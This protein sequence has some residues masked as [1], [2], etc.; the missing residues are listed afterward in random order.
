M[1]SL[2]L[3]F[4]LAASAFAG[5]LAEVELTADPP[6]P[7]VQIHSVRFTPSETRTYD[8]LVFTCSYRQSFSQPDASGSVTN[9]TH[10]PGFPFVYRE[11]NAHLVA[12]LDKYIAFRVPVNVQEL[13]D[14]FGKTAFVTNAPVT[15]QSVKVQALT[16]G[17]EDWK[18]SIAPG[19]KIHP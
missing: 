17:K 11:K 13:R 12:G 16:G 18:F 1:R 6:G 3:F 5:P 14:Q 15:I 10:T 7:R 2:A 4:V 8:E 19:E 9:K